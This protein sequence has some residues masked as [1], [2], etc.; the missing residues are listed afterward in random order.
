MESGVDLKSV[1]K[2]WGKAPKSVIWSVGRGWW[3]VSA[4]RWDKRRRGKPEKGK[5]LNLYVL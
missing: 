2:G 4:E 1:N 5:R 3:M